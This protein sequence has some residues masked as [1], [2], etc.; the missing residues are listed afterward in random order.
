M[1][2]L[3][4]LKFNLSTFRRYFKTWKGR[5]PLTAHPSRDHFLSMPW[6][7]FFCKLLTPRKGDFI[8]CPL[9]RSS[10]LLTHLLMQVRA[11]TCCLL[12][13]RITPL[14]DSTKKRLE[15]HNWSPWN[16]WSL[17]FK[18]EKPSNSRHLRWNLPA[19]ELQLNIQNTEKGFG[20]SVTVT[21]IY[22]SAW[23]RLD[24]LMN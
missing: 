24:R 23:Q 4:S 19:G 21:R 10:V 20:C 15:N 7:F 14:F 16:S 8:L 12:A 13:L 11:M 9:S 6:I 1:S 17:F 2:T 18:K 3:T 22:S 5:F